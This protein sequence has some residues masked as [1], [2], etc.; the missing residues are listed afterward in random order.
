MTITLPIGCWS[1]PFVALYGPMS[2]LSGAHREYLIVV[3]VFHL[4][5]ADCWNYKKGVDCGCDGKTLEYC[6]SSWQKFYD[7]RH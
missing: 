3:P 1:Q 5:H 6:T 7:K 2:G 4:I